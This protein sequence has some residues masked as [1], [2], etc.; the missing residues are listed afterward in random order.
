M[1]SRVEHPP[2]ASPAVADALQI[3]RYRR[4]DRDDVLA[5]IGS[6][7]SA[8]HRDR[9]AAQWAWKYDANP[10]G[11]DPD[12]YLLLLKDGERIVGTIADVPVR[13][14][15]GGA[16]RLVTCTCDLLVHPEQR[17]RGLSRVLIEQNVADHPVTFAWTNAASAR[18]CERDTSRSHRVH[19][20][21]LPLD[22]A[23]LAPLLAGRS[24]PVRAGSRLAAL[25]SGAVGH[26]P[27]RPRRDG[28]RVSEITAFDARFDDLWRRQA[29]PARVMVVRDRS[30]LDW[31]FARRP[32]VRYAIL[33]ALAG[34]ALLGYLVLR[35]A[36]RSGIRWGY[37]VDFLVEAP[38]AWTALVDAALERFHGE[39]VALAACTAL[40]PAHQRA[41]YRRGF[42]QWR[43]ASPGFF[44]LRVNRP[45]PVWREFAD[46]RRWFA[47]MGDGDL[48]MSF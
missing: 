28:I 35:T 41:L 33:A 2:V 16:A 40:A 5:F 11:D 44:Y 36:G 6:V 39:G 27:R 14:W 48:E 25:A 31:R 23:A 42:F 10:F 38:A 34:E 30:Y 21:V 15:V 12:P 45:E 3:A 37:L 13:V 29:T 32:D 26:R 46:V 24:W 47:T 20:L 7:A 17:L 22:R 43:W 1:V 9:L 4:A 8:R 18:A 19:P